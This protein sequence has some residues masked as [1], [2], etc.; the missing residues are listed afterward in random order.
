MLLEDEASTVLNL[1][2]VAQG[3]TSVSMNEA[4]YLTTGLTEACRPR[5]EEHGHVR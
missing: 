4:Q 2:M 5:W 1:F 3:A